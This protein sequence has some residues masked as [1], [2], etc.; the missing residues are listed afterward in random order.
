MEVLFGENVEGGTKNFDFGSKFDLVLCIVWIPF[1]MWWHMGWR[2]HGISLW[3]G[4]F[5]IGEG[6]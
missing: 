5:F 2:F 6:N 1:C 3:W 4:F